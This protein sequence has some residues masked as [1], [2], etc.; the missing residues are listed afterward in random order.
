[1]RVVM[2]GFYLDSVKLV[3]IVKIG[4]DVVYVKFEGWLLLW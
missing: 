3:D 1:M 4:E 2:L